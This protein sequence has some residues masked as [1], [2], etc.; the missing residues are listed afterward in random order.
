MDKGRAL[1]Y[2]AP[3]KLL[4]NE[5]GAFTGM[6]RETG[7]A[8]EKFLRSMAAGDVA[9]QQELQQA[10]AVALVAVS[11][12]CTAPEPANLG[13]LAKNVAQ[14]A[15][16]LNQQLNGLLRQLQAQMAA[17]GDSLSAQLQAD[18]GTFMQ[19][20][21]GG[22]AAG[23]TVVVPYDNGH[24]ANAGGRTASG[25]A[26]IAMQQLKAALAATSQ[27]QQVAANVQALLRPS[28]GRLSGGDT[29]DTTAASSDSI[30]PLPSPV[31]T[32][33]GT[34]GGG[35]LSAEWSDGRRQST[36]PMTTGRLLSIR[37]FPGYTSGD[38]LSM[39]SQKQHASGEVA[40]IAAEVQAE[41]DTSAAG[42]VKGM[43]R[44]PSR[45]LQIRCP[46]LAQ[47]EREQRVA[48]RQLSTA[49]AAGNRE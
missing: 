42:I 39:W 12:P 49:P 35:R 28:T 19:E 7:E 17:D 15:V 16:I 23:G 9:A 41:D 21:D 25:T 13:A 34:R 32:R 20:S 38:L 18:G 40:A 45:S 36:D 43:S 4:E 3:G 46:N 8:T 33:R 48:S 14:N 29:D 31:P 22:V 1:E 24:A 5:S 47:C 10:A 44:S 6:V 11:L 2:G 27:L 37:S 26:V 30:S